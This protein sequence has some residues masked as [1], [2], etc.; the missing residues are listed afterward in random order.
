[1]TLTLQELVD[2]MY[3]VLAV[4]TMF[5]TVAEC[6]A[7]L[8]RYAALA[9]EARARYFASRRGCDDSEPEPDS[10]QSEGSIWCDSD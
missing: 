2:F 9:L 3:I 4:V 7:G 5:S 6:A 1:M 8:M 10:D